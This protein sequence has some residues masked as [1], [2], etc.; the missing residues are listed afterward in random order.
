MIHR[1]FFSLSTC[2][3]VAAFAVGTIAP[4]TA[5]SGTYWVAQSGTPHLGAGTSCDAPDAVG[6]TE[7]PIQTA[8]NASVGGGIV[9]ICAGLYT[10]G[11][12]ITLAGPQGGL[13]IEGAG[14]GS[15]S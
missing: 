4:A 14:S 12:P 10:I 2:L 9:H 11:T 1:L 6:T 13:A 8:V 7:L 3:L 5:V 15:R